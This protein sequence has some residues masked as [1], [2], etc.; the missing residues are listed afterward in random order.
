MLIGIS[1]ITHI[2]IVIVRVGKEQVVL[3]KNETTAQ[4]NV[5]QMDF[6]WILGS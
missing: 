1:V 5:G 6:L 2:V 3:G 4:I